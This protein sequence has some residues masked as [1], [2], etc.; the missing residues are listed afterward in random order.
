ML[1]GDAIESLA[2]D[3]AQSLL[4]ELNAS[5]RG[6]F[7]EALSKLP[8]RP[9][10]ARAM[11]YERDV[12]A[13]GAGRMMSDALKHLG[14]GEDSLAVRAILAATER[15]RAMWYEELLAEYG[16]VIE[17]SKLPLPEANKELQRLEAEVQ[18]SPNPLIRLLMPSIV[19]TNQKHAR[20]DARIAKLE[21]TLLDTDISAGTTN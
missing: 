6:R 16:K 17:A 21:T 3:V 9:T 12:F 13:R 11:S 5:S 7:A 20:I 14:T 4:P 15:K 18:D 2:A 8:T 19:G 10:F 1:V